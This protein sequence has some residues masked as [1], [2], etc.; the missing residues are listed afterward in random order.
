MFAGRCLYVLS[1]AA[2]CAADLERLLK[3]PYLLPSIYCGEDKGVGDVM[4]LNSAHERGDVLNVY[5]DTG[6]GWEAV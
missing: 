2:L 5:L 4:I 1:L 3:S 6:V